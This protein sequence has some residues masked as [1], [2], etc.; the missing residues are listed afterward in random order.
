ME[1][2]IN[3]PGV[4]AHTLVGETTSAHLLALRQYGL[5]CLCWELG[6]QV[7]SST[8]TLLCSY[9]L[10]S[11]FSVC[12][13]RWAAGPALSPWPK[14]CIRDPWTHSF[15]PQLTL[16]INDK[17]LT[18]PDV[19]YDEARNL[20]NKWL[21]HQAFAAE[22]ASHQGWLENIDAVSKASGGGS[23]LS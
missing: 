2:R 16:W 1:R 5:S 13:Q 23:L 7:E 3:I 8:L 4:T 12:S 14:R 22:L 17:L 18:S 10:P 6:I 9:F 20:H 19:S 21:K 11:A 15:Y